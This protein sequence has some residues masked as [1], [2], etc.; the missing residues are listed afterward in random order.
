MK[1]R[2]ER[3][4]VAER[5]A[6]DAASV[7]LK[8]LGVAL[9]AEA[10]VHLIAEVDAEVFGVGDP[11]V[12]MGQQELAD[13]RIEGEA[14]DA[15]PGRIDE[16]RARP[17]GDVAR[18]DQIPAGLEELEF[19]GRAGLFL[20]PVDAENGAHGHVE[21]DV[22]GAVEGVEN[23]E[24]LAHRVLVG[25]A[26]EFGVL[27]GGEAGSP[28]SPPR[29]TPNSCAFPTST[30]WASTSSF[31]TPSTAPRTSTSTCPWAPFSA[32]TGGK[33]SPARP[34]N[35]SSSSPAGI[36]SQRATSPTGRARCSSIRPGT[37][38]TASPS[39]RRSASSCCPIPT[40]GSPTPNTSAST[41]A[42]RCTGASA[43]SATPNTFRATEAASKACRSAT[44]ARSFRIFIATY[45]PAGSSTTVS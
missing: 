35:S 2:N 9:D 21:V 1:I 42:M 20:P 28:A 39:I 44:S 40:S 23:E 17:V 16:H 11:D 6:F 4:D 30:R 33:K 27:L 29:R 24:V 8:V 22:R 32:S 37:A 19:L 18:C 7:A 36:W 12:G 43:S 15:V 25:N 3:A 34:R 14:V 38:S 41:S 10:P 5:Q 13:R 26:H 31:S 45:S